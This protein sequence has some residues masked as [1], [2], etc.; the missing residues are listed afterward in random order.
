MDGKIPLWFNSLHENNVDK[1]KLLKYILTGDELRSKLTRVK[2]PALIGQIQQLYQD[3][4]D[5]NNHSNDKLLIEED[6]LK[7]SL[8]NSSNS[9]TSSSNESPLNIVLKYLSGIDEVRKG[10]TIKILIYSLT[11]LFPFNLLTDHLNN[12]LW[13]QFLLPL[14]LFPTILPIILICD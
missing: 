7:S 13:Y 10:R 6:K 2:L 5:L 1:E 8:N 11:S 4:S 12:F 9:S 14:L 3:Y